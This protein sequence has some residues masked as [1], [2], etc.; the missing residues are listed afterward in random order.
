M[1]TGSRPYRSQLQP[2]Q[3][4][5]RDEHQ[6]REDEAGRGI[7]LAGQLQLVGTLRGGRGVDPG[8]GR[9]E[10]A[11]H[12]AAAQVRQHLVLVDGLP[13]GVGQVRVAVAGRGVQLDLAVALALVEVEQDGEPVIEALAT[14]AVLVDE[15][16][17]IRL[18]Q[19]RACRSPA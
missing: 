11:A 14:D 19:V 2:A 13:V 8:Q 9:V 3:R 16:T 15:G 12:V 1:Y 4:D 6:R 5:E 18:R 17:C 10:G 7:D